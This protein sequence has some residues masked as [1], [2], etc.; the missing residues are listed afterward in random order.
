[1]KLRTTLCV[2]LPLLCCVSLPLAAQSFNEDAWGRNSPGVALQTAEG[3]RE[4]TASGTQLTYMLAG[5]GFP[6]NLTY[7]LWGWIPGRKPQMAIDGVTFN[8][9]GLLVCNPTSAS[10]KGE[11][12]DAPIKIKTTAV[13]GE[14]KRFAVVSDD[15]R[16]AG[17]TEVVPFPIEATS[18]NCKVSVVRETPL[19]E[20]VMVSATGFVPYEMLNVSANLGGEDTV[21]SPTTSADGSWQAVVGTK[22]PGKESGTSSIKVSGQQCSVSLTFNWGEG[23]A[24]EQ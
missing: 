4:P 18:K 10:C 2:L 6:S 9:K 20:K 8:A 21:H 16:V 7:A 19:A 22:A 17:F 12:P 5:K 15:G 24:K 3:P 23:S 1:M 14:P 11:A 13:L